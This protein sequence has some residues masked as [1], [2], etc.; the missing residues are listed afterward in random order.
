M[1]PTAVAVSPI[2]LKNS[3]WVG[4]GARKKTVSRISS[5]PPNP[6]SRSSLRSS[7]NRPLASTDE[8]DV[9]HGDRNP[10]RRKPARADGRGSRRRVRHQPPV[11]STKR[12]RRAG[13]STTVRRESATESSYRPRRPHGF[14][15]AG[16]FEAVHA[17][18]G[19][20]LA[21]IIRAAL[22]RLN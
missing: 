12:N 10:Y 14:G 22:D 18:H 5:C 9:S 8:P 19:I 2:K 1:R 15:Q 21:S 6:F 16:S 4:P 13:G 3:G 11:C 7:P 17:H 20:D